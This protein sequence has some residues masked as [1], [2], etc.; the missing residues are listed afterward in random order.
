MSVP[1]FEEI[2]KYKKEMDKPQA[3]VI[4]HDL[5]G[6]NGIIAPILYRHL[7]Q[8]SVVTPIKVL[9]IG[10][11]DRALWRSFVKCRLRCTY[12]S[13]DIGC[14][15]EHDFQDISQVTEN[16]NAICMFE[17]IEH[18]TIEETDKLL[19]RVYDLLAPGGQVYIST[20]NPFHPTRF[21]SDI[22]HKQHWPDTDLFAMLR[23]LG[24]ERDKI[25]MY[26]IIYRNNFSVSNL[27]DFLVRRLRDF[28]WRIIG[29]DIRGG[30][31]AIATK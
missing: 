22:T 19:H 27:P 4:E 6:R 5:I 10:A 3:I 15:E 14:A 2:L 18:L 8:I 11:Y 26:G 9:D 1:S 13:L 7:K 28:V 20:P 17:L 24:F 16:Y 31:L 30:F 12:H 21:F 29:I 23:H 25:K